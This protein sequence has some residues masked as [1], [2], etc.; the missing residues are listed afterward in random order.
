MMLVVSVHAWASALAANQPMSREHVEAVNRTRRIIFHH[1]AGANTHFPLQNVGPERIHD[2]V[3]LLV[4]P[5]DAPGNQIDSVWYD[6]CEGNHAV[7]RSEILPPLAWGAYPGWW[8]AG[9][10]IVDLVLNA[11][12]QRGREVFFTYRINGGDHDFGLRIPPIKLEH[13]EW[14]HDAYAGLG[15]DKKHIFWNFAFKEVRDYKL[16]VLRELAENYDFDGISVDWCSGAVCFPPG[17]QWLHRNQLTDFMRRVRRMML[18]V[19]KQRGRPLLLA[20]RVPENI[21]GCQFDGIDI[22][23]W[24]RE[25]LVDIIVLGIRSSEVDFNAFRSLAMGT[26]IKLYPSFDY[27]HTSDSYDY[28]PIEYSRGIYANWWQQGADGGY[29]FNN[30]HLEPSLAAKLD[31]SRSKQGWEMECQRFREIG[32]PQTLAFLDKV[33]FVQRRGYMDGIIV[34]KPED[35][36]TPRHK[37]TGTNMFEALPAAIP[38]D[39]RVDRL[40]TLRV[41]DDVNAARDR[42]EKLTLRLALLDPEAEQLPAADRYVGVAGARRHNP[43]PSLYMARGIE[44]VIEVRVNNVLLERGHVVEGWLLFPVKPEQLALG[45]NLIG[46]RMTERRPDSA[47]PISIEKL[48]LRVDYR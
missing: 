13:P 46:V 14:T 37:Y 26:G 44:Q 4:S 24:I 1:D 6:W 28:T 3:Q 31:A 18:D 10:D 45:D 12:R 20:V 48:E 42:I 16:A 36:W 22:R 8:E 27:V 40:L 9:H 21:M 19:E 41:G 30:Y 39:P 47:A 35:W 25:Q 38:D 7:W 17:E 5:L 29:M 34:P 11:A 32:D 33:F 2:V 43:P 15:Y 23:A